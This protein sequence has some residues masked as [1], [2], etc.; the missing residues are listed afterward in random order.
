MYRLH[1]L[2]IASIAALIIVLITAA[3]AHSLW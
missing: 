2:L 1:A 3:M